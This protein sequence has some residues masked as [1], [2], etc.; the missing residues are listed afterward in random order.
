MRR[1][2]FVGPRIDE[3]AARGLSVE[4]RDDV[5]ERLVGGEVV[6]QIL[7]PW[8]WPVGIGGGAH[9]DHY[10]EVGVGLHARD[11]EAGNSLS[12]GELL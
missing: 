2:K 12:H 1:C 9:S 11:L 4:S 10:L 7:E 5:D 6:P 3:A 8:R